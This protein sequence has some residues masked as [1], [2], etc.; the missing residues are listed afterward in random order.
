M[1]PYRTDSI[2]AMMKLNKAFYETSH[3]FRV[4]WEPPEQS[5]DGGYMKWF[6][7]DKFIT[8]VEGSDVY[9]TSKAEI[10]S[11]PMYLLMNLAVSRSWGFQ[12]AWYK[13]CPKKC[14]TCLDPE[15][16]CALPKGFCNN[17]P[18]SF[19]IDSVRVYQPL[20][21]D[22]RY[23]LGCS[24]PHRPTKKYIEANKKLY[25]E[26]YEEEPLLEIQVGGG[27]CQTDDDCGGTIR[28]ICTG[29]LSCTCA[30]NWTG[31]TCL[32]H[33]GYLEWHVRS[34]SDVRRST[35]EWTIVSCLALCIFLLLQ[36]MQLAFNE[37][38][39]QAYTI[40]NTISPSDDLV[41]RV[42]TKS[43]YD[44]YQKGGDKLSR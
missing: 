6:I 38:E 18:T 17:L 22:R 15:C 14:W 34:D 28:G 20:T 12:N 30:P 36:F 40:L 10:P 11:E 32:A 1:T 33:R 16:E 35:L 5:G 24:P 19:V 9:K 3:K 29:N 8:A 37:P 4:E 31:P 27:P 39:K 21:N 41:V 23:S 44:S 25:K 43:P 26:P 7:D 13:N 42:D 2:S